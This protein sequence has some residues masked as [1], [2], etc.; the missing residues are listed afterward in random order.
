MRQFDNDKIKIG[1]S[2]C[3]EIKNYP[4]AIAYGD[5]LYFCTTILM[6]Q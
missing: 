6:A 3:L 1:L 5:F 4:N 2:F